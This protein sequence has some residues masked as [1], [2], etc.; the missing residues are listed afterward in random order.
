MKKLTTNKTLLLALIAFS[1]FTAKGFAQPWTVDAITGSAPGFITEFSSTG[2]SP[3]YIKN[4]QIYDYGTSLIFG[5][6]TNPLGSEYLSIQKNQNSLSNSLISN[7]YNTSAASSAYNA[8][9]NG[10]SINMQAFSTGYSTSGINVQGAVGLIGS[11]TGMTQ[12]NLGTSTSTPLTFWTANTQQMALNAS[13]QLILG[14]TTT[15]GGEFLSIQ[16]NLTSATVARIS[17]TNSS[18]AVNYIATTNSGGGAIAMSAYSSSY[19]SSG[20]AQAGAAVI[21]SSGTSL[22]IGMGSSAP[23]TFWTSGTQRIIINSVGNMGILNP[24]PAYPLDVAGSAHISGQ[25]WLGSQRQNSSADA[26]HQ[27]AALLV[28]GDMVVGTSGTGA[29]ANIW[30]TEAN[31]ADFVFDSNYKLMPLNEVENFYKTNHHLPNVPTAKEIKET[32]NNLAQT[33]VVLLQKIEENTLYIVELKKQL[34]TQQKL[35]EELSKKWSI[36]NN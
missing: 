30:V 20:I 17:N 27:S 34:E 11:G 21:S 22:N 18:G 26:P 36:K 9:A 29:H 16:K 15:L 2:S 25:L 35:I 31:W 14:A 5:G 33:D 32:G 10:P 12:M 13:G 7:N 23:I 28:N 19:S 8:L 24:S 4:S 3:S 1:L 6:Y